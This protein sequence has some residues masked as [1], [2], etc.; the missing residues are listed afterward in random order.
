M[1]LRPHTGVNASGLYG[2]TDLVPGVAG[3]FT[4]GPVLRLGGGA[5]TGSNPA[6]LERRKARAEDGWNM[7]ESRYLLGFGMRFV[8]ICPLLRFVNIE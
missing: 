3:E 8:F 1:A 7:R 5:G 4:P 6:V 2:S